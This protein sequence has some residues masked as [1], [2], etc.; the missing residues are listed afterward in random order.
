VF[1]DCPQFN[2]NPDERKA[3]RKKYFEERFTA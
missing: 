1:W 2:M 3:L